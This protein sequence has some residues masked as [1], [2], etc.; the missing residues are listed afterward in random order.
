LFGV[1]TDGYVREY[2][3]DSATNA[4]T[5][6]DL[7][8]LPQF[9]QGTQLSVW[10]NGS[11]IDLFGVHAGG[12][13][14]WLHESGGSWTSSAV[15]TDGGMSAGT[16]L[17]IAELGGDVFLF[18]VNGSGTVDEI[19]Y[20]GTAWSSPSTLS[21]GADTFAN[22]S[23]LGVK[24]WASNGFTLFGVD[25]NGQIK[26]VFNYGSGLANQALGGAPALSTS[27]SIAFYSDSS[28]IQQVFGATPGGDL[29]VFNF[30]LGSGAWNQYALGG[31]IAPNTLSNSSSASVA[32]A[33]D[34]NEQ[35]LFVVG[36]DGLV[37]EDRYSYDTNSDSGLAVID[38]NTTFDPAAKLTAFTVGSSVNL[39]G[40]GQNGQA[41]WAQSTAAGGWTGFVS[42]DSVT[43][44]PAVTFAAGTALAG[45]VRGGS[46]DLF[47]VGTDGH[48]KQYVYDGGGW[49]FAS[50]DRLPFFPAG[51]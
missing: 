8:N 26:N 39:F 9:S 5:L 13:I 28:G 14:E 48:V 20:D 6:D 15:A 4:W 7:N 30:N 38:A 44:N 11:S 41:L 21:V 17:A 45:V 46:L 25:N 29:A 16:P 19:T 12:G 3:Y 31:S 34:L 10:D 24:L 47:A 35:D 36:A 27:S 42:L 37:R 2:V 49:T 50:L 40:V 43:G 1:G 51:P 33:G 32:I 18:G 23:A 22:N